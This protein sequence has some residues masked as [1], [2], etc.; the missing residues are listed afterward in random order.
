MPLLLGRNKAL[1]DSTKANFFFYSFDEG[2]HHQ[3]EQGR[4]IL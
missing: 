1:F 3:D 2:S 4:I